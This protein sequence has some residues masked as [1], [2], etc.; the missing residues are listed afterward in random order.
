MIEILDS[1]LKKSQQFVPETVSGYIALQLARQLDDIEHVWN[2]LA[3]LDRQP[4]SAIVAALT[5]AKTHGNGHHNARGI[6]EREFAPFLR[7]G[8]DHA[9]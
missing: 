7:K 5:K 1:M 9:A 8:H 4:L 2:Y 3:L 6:F